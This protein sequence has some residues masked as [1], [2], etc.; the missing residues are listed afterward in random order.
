MNE[1]CQCGH[2][3]DEHHTNS[4]RCL[5]YMCDCPEFEIYTKRRPKKKKL[6]HKFRDWVADK[7]IDEVEK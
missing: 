4:K 6:L 1:E 3:K 5:I 2:R 7:L